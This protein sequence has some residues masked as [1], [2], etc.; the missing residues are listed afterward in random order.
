MIRPA[1]NFIFPR[2]VPGEE[3]ALARGAVWLQ[4]EPD[5]AP[6]FLAQ[7]ALG[8]T[9]PSVATG[10]W[11]TP[12]PAELCCIAGGYAYRINT[13]APEEAVLLPVQPV[14]AVHAATAAHA[15][16][17]VGHHHVYVLSA[18]GVAWRSGRIS[19]EG[20]V[21][22]SSD[23]DILRGRGWDMLRD[24]EVPFTL[25]LHTREL[26]GGGFHRGEDV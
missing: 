10:V 23:E 21:V 5:H 2:V 14:V 17:L 16:V 19:W 11:S 25:D 18:S 26:T 13:A 3:E 22:E 20:V 6:T 12:V 1:R 9:G 24:I 7:C 8:Y 4:V 15:L